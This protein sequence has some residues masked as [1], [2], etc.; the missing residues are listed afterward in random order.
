[1]R[2]KRN[3]K[4]IKKKLEWSK[5]FTLL[6]VLFGFVIAQECL[7]IMVFC[8][9]RDFSSTAAYLTAGVG[10]AEAIIG[11]GLAGY[12]SLCKV[13]HQSAEGEGI[14]YATAK[15]KNFQ[16]DIEDEPNI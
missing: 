14:T 13:D 12:L 1:M 15:A 11:S 5:I 10:L 4:K 2:R 3:K 16:E 9:W 6:V 8:I 7:A